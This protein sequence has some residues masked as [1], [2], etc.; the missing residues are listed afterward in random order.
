MKVFSKAYGAGPLHLLG[1]AALVLVAAWAL[2]IM[3]RPEFAPQPLNLVLWLL[4]GAVIHDFVLLPAYSAVN[5]GATRL[6]GASTSINYLRAPLIAS[7][8]L[9]LAFLPRIL[10]RQPQNFERALGHAPPDFLGR[11][12]LVTALLFA[13][14]ALVWGVRRVRHQ[15]LNA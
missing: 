10:N 15:G 12:L 3:F 13:A 4:G 7:L 11:W 6:L 5:I 1:H 8:V 2:S 14:S 9:L